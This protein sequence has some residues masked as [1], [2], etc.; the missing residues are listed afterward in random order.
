HDRP[1]LAAF[2]AGAA[3]VDRRTRHER[4]GEDAGHGRAGIE[5]RHHQVA[6]ALVADAAM[7]RRELDASNE[8]QVGKA[9]RSE[10]RKSG[11]ASL[12][13]VGYAR[14]DGAGALTLWAWSRARASAVLPPA[15]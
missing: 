4:A 5:H 7:R 15:A 10:R 12:P 6:P 13:T 3:P 1:R 14:G 8:R 2:E 11:H 9:G